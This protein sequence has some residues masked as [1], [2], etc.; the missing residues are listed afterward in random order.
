MKIPS[1]GLVFSGH[2]SRTQDFTFILC[3]LNFPFHSFL[4]PH[5]SL[6]SSFSFFIFLSVS[7]LHCFS[8]SGTLTSCRFFLFFCSFL[9]FL[10]SEPSFFSPIPISF[11]CHST[12]VFLLPK[13]G[14]PCHIAHCQPPLPFLSSSLSLIPLFF[15]FYALPP[16]SLSY[17]SHFLT[18]SRFSYSKTLLISPFL[19][20]SLIYISLFLYLSVSLRFY[21]S[22]TP[23]EPTSPYFMDFWLCP[24]RLHIYQRSRNLPYLSSSYLLQCFHQRSCLLSRLIPLRSSELA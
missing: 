16:S 21:L 5:L 13:A 12:S 14:T 2:F 9:C 4:S 22:F 11:T 7:F 24:D 15:G 17:V 3:C 1:L 10:P 18:F 6:S 8:M 23:F 19:C 20:F